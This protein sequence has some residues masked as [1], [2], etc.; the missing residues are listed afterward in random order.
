VGDA[1][2]LIVDLLGADRVL[3][4]SASRYL[5]EPWVKRV[6]QRAK[7]QTGY[8]TRYEVV[9]ASLGD[10]LQD[11]SALAAAWRVSPSRS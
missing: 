4:G 1:V 11:C 5:G 7:S 8:W 6:R 2:A 3:L 9:A 10:R